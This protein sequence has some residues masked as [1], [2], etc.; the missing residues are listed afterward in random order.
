MVRIAHAVITPLYCLLALGEPHNPIGGGG[1][2]RALNQRGEGGLEGV[3]GMC[4]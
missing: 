3:L 1:G 2:T 4:N